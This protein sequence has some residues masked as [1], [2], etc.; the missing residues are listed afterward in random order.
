M[1]II[2]FNT[3]YSKCQSIAGDSSS[4]SLTL[5]KYW[6][7]RG[8]QKAYSILDTEYFITSATDATAD[9][10]SSYPLP[11]NCE[12]LHSYK[13]TISSKDYVAIEFPGSEND[14]I[15]LI[16]GATT[17]SEST[18]PTYFFQK[19]NTVE[20]WPT[21][22]T[23][24]Y[25]ITLRFK[26]NT[27]NLSQ[28]DYTTGNITTLAS[29]G[30]AV[31]GSGT[32]WTAAFVGRYFKINTDGYWYE[33]STRTADTAITLAREYGGTAIATGSASYTIGEA[34]LLPEGYQD[35]PLFYALFRY[36]KFKRKQ[37]IALDYGNDWQEGLENLAADTGNLTTS[38]VIEEDIEILDYNSWASGLS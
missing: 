24:S 19:R 30:T 22:S 26:R 28:S 10:T 18:Y 3:L 9:G 7:N 13:T 6:L 11:Y 25:V 5:F 20:I 31:T 17:A 34:S 37:D 1:E 32:T 14:W 36:F 27:K 2:S 33:I 21:S 12:K 8:I 29:A 23:D 35:L 16:G 38:G 15:G 4:A